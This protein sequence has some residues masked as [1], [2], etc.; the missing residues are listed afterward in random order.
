MPLASFTWTN[1]AGSADW[2]DPGNWTPA[3]IP[4]LGLDTAADAL[5]NLLDAAVTIPTGTPPLTLADLTITGAGS[6]LSTLFNDQSLAVT[7]QLTMDDAAYWQFGTGSFAA[8]Q[9]TNA[10]FHQVGGTLG[11]G[12]TD[13]TNTS[14]ALGYNATLSFAGPVSAGDSFFVADPSANT[15]SFADQG[16]ALASPI[17]NLQTGD[18]IDLGGLAWNSAYTISGTSG[19][20]W[21]IAL[22]GEPV[23]TFSDLALL[24]ALATVANPFT[25]ARD[26]SGGTELQVAP[27]FIWSNPTDSYGTAWGYAANWTPALVPGLAGTT[28]AEVYILTAGYGPFTDE[29]VTFTIASL[30]MEGVAGNQATLTG[31]GGLNVTGAMTL[32]YALATLTTASDFI[33]GTP[34][35][36]DAALSLVLTDGSEIYIRSFTNPEDQ[37]FPGGVLV[38]YGQT[39]VT[40][41]T[42]AITATSS[43]TAGAV[44]LSGT[45]ATPGV[46][47]D[48]GAETLGALTVADFGQ[49]AESGT[50]TIGA[51]TTPATTTTLTIAAGA[52]FAVSGSL[53]VYGQLQSTGGSIAVTGSLTAGATDDTATTWDINGGTLSLSGFVGS[54]DTFDFLSPTVSTLIFGA[55][56][57]AFTGTIGTFDSI[58]VIDL[59]QLTWNPSYTLS[60]VSGGA[61]TIDLGNTVAFTFSDIT[62]ADDVLGYPGTNPVYLKPDTTGGTEVTVMPLVFNYVVN[63]GPTNGAWT[64]AANWS[65]NAVPGTSAHPGSIVYLN[66]QVGVEINATDPA[67]SVSQLSLGIGLG[68][69]EPLSVYGS[70]TVTSFLAMATESMFYVQG[71]AVVGAPD[72]PTTTTTLTLGNIARLIV[73]GSMTVHG[74]LQAGMTDIVQVYGGSFSAGSADDAQVAWSLD[75]SAKI[76]FSGQVSGLGTDTFKFDDATASTL[77]FGAQGSSFGGTIEN[78]SGSNI[79]DLKQLAWN[80]NY[81]IAPTSGGTGVTISLGGTTEFTFASFTRANNES[82]GLQLAPDSSTGTD[83]VIACFAAGTRIATPTGETPVQSLRPGDLVLTQAGPQP[84]IW[85]GRRTIDLTRH[86]NPEAARPIRIAA[87]A[88]AENTPARDLLVSPDHAIFHNGA[89]IPA[90]HLLNAQTITQDRPHT[91]TYFHVELAHHAILYAASLPAESYLDTGNRAAFEGGATLTL[92]PHF[93]V[94]AWHETCAPMITDGPRLTAAR[95]HLRARARK[96]G[97]ATTANPDLHL[98]IDGIRIDPQKLPDGR[99]RLAIPKDARTIR[100]ISRTAIPAEQ[101]PASSDRRRLGVCIETIELITPAGRIA[102]TLTH[103]AL[104]TGWHPPEAAWRWTNGDAGLDLR[105]PCLVHLRLAGKTRYPSPAPGHSRLALT[106]SR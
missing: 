76:A 84:I 92:H 11:V 105:G 72:T 19:G 28:D 51:P 93:P 99:L 80:P 22:A 69:V 104:T 15:L 44:T 71:T 86:P 63:Y 29:N 78:F 20:A 73:F 6:A 77:S 1:G 65:P 43:F 26:P 61:W 18:V 87:H 42:I 70:L 68:G 60:G 74:G 32:Q 48:A 67:I 97:H 17:V 27:I 82:L 58:N 40:S 30:T 5:I 88:F 45:A 2:T 8:V 90:K 85:T 56:G 79:V 9:A 46:L 57:N 95:R 14:W 89:L 64:N 38:V 23:F 34:A 103:P 62:L 102:P 24:G 37:I 54:G 4:G 106:L 47:E 7:T 50:G 81:V 31:N 36:P 41:S 3:G 33:I 12:S 13:D 39:Q 96:L 59:T 52:L 101:H 25:L 21:T 10:F 35:T 53:T 83:V 55:Q 75:Q 49:F 100:L 98:L 91:V 94:H 16:S 66:G